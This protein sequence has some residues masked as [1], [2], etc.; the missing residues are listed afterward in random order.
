M[1]EPENTSP[2]RSTSRSTREASPGGSSNDGRCGTYFLG[3]Y[4][5][6]DE[7][8]VGGMATVELARMDGAGGFQKWV[9]IKRIHQHL[10]EDVQFI[11]MFL[12]EARIAASISHPNVAQVFDLGRHEHQYWIAMEYLHGEPLREVMRRNEELGQPMR[13][14]LAARVIADAAEGLHAAHE[15]RGKDGRPL[16]LVHRDVSPHNLFVTYDGVVKV[17]DFGI[18]KVAGSLSHTHAGMLKGKLAYMAPE[19]V[20]DRR[21][22]RRTDIFALGVVL[23]ELTTGRRLFRVESD[24]GTLSLV[25]ACVVPRPASMDAAYPADLESVLLHALQKEPE[26]R[27]Q[28]AREFSRALQRYL[29]NANCFVGPEEISEYLTSLFEDRVHQRKEHLRWAAEVTQTV[30]I[31]NVRKRADPHDLLDLSALPRSTDSSDSAEFDTI[32]ERHALDADG[33]LSPLG[34]VNAPSDTEGVQ[35]P[36]VEVTPRQPNGLRDSL[37]E[38]RRVTPRPKIGKGLTTAASESAASGRP[39]GSPTESDPDDDDDDD[40]PTL[41]A[42]APAVEPELREKLACAFDEPPLPANPELPELAD[43]SV[44]CVIDTIAFADSDQAACLPRDACV[45][46]PPPPDGRWLPTTPS[47]APSSL[48]GYPSLPRPHCVLVGEEAAQRCV[49]LDGA[50]A[51]Q[52]TQRVRQVRGPS[53]RVLWAAA[54]GAAFVGA[55]VAALLWARHQA[56]HLDDSRMLEPPPASAVGVGTAVQDA[57]GEG[58]DVGLDDAAPPPTLTSVAPDASLSPPAPTLKPPAPRATAVRKRVVAPAVSILPD[59]GDPTEPPPPG[60]L[61]VICRPA[62]DQVSAGRYALGRGASG[63]PLPPGQYRVRLKRGNVEKTITAIVV[64]GQRTSHV[65]SME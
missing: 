1:M 21:I 10:T 15:L 40:V 54:V 42:S 34:N 49:P 51:V 29:M 60:F 50:S 41:I 2:K 55:G 56:A 8:G 7:L 39:N 37:V 61:T 58:L 57:T 36:S 3:P 19:Q 35:A 43:L 9:A 53:N 52:A 44:D 31:E 4:R 24:L 45:L 27:F 28:T 33:V 5:V 20:R 12:D 11:N 46:D 26:D 48:G 47:S 16:N 32:E 22:D 14:E 63:P 64:S 6:V 30:S 62:C 13:P 23:W 25:E 59:D 38:T 65:V 18:A 17:V